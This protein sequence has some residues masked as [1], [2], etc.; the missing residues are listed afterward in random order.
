MLSFC[1]FQLSMTSL[2]LCA[3]AISQ[4]SPAI[5]SETP[6]PYLSLC[7]MSGFS[8]LSR[9]TS[10]CMNLLKSVSFFRP[11][12]LLVFPVDAAPP[13]CQNSVRNMHR[14]AYALFALVVFFVASAPDWALVVTTITLEAAVEERVSA[15]GHLH[16]KRDARTDLLG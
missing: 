13:D 10:V 2:N 6:V 4:R 5:T 16:R 1:L 7:G 8:C 9:A 3:R 14:R 11:P 15:R 12:A